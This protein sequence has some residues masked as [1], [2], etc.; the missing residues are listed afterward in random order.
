[1]Q[2]SSSELAGLTRVGELLAEAVGQSHCHCA[3][4]NGTADPPRRTVANVAGGEQSRETG[5]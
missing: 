3:I 5:L 1:M 2:H 4:A